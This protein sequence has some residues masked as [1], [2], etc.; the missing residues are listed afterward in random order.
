LSALL[1]YP[2]SE[3]HAYKKRKKVLNLPLSE[4]CSAV[5][6][7]GLSCNSNCG[8]RDVL[9]TKRV[10]IMASPEAE[11]FLWR[12]ILQEMS[13]FFNQSRAPEWKRAEDF[14]IPF[15]GSRA[16]LRH[17]ICQAAVSIPTRQPGNASTPT[18]TC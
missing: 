11:T 10:W 13:G 17:N 2:L 8:L 6:A 7:D 4:T 1:F 14:I 3:D 15:R 16:F 9:G 5:S 12:R 18:K